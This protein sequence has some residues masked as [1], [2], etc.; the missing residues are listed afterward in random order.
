MDTVT[1]IN[2]LEKNRA[3]IQAQ[4]EHETEE[5][6][7]WKPGPDK[8]CLLEIICHLYDE[9]RED[10]RTR[11]ALT[12]EKPGQPLPPFNP[13][14]WVTER[15]YIKQ[16]YNERLHMFLTERVSS[17]QW[18]RSLRNPE[19]ENSYDHPKLGPMTAAL[20]LNSWLA[21]DYLHIRQINKNKYLYLREHVHTKLDY[22]GTW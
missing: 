6:C 15:E 19:W 22:A 4:L 13:L 1:I 11:V 18:L 12:L 7:V 8:W 9:E 14:S 17:V 20:F 21:H 2:Q 16:D 5:V 10:F 3:I